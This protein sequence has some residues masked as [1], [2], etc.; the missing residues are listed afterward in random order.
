MRVFAAFILL[1]VTIFSDVR[2]VKAAPNGE[3][4]VYKIWAV[5]TQNE[6]G[7][8][9]PIWDTM[10]IADSQP[11]GKELLAKF[12]NEGT[13][14]PVDED[15]GIML[16]LNNSSID[17]TAAGVTVIPDKGQ[18]RMA[19]N[20]SI[21]YGGLVAS[22]LDGNIDDD[23]VFPAFT[24]DPTNV[25]DIS[26]C[27][28][29]YPYDCVTDE[30]DNIILWPKHRKYDV[31]STH[32]V[33]DE[34]LFAGTLTVN[35]DVTLE[36]KDYD[37]EG[38]GTNGGFIEASW[39]DLQ[40]KI[41]MDKPSNEWAPAFIRVYT[42]GWLNIG[43][44]GSLEVGDGTELIFDDN[45]TCNEALYSQMIR[46]D[47]SAYVWNNT[48]GKLRFVYFEE[49]DKWVY[50]DPKFTVDY[51][52]CWRRDEEQEKDVQTGIV[53]VNGS[54]VSREDRILFNEGEELTFS[55][56][57]PEDRAGCSINVCVESEEYFY[58]TWADGDEKLTITDNSFSFTPPNSDQFWVR[59]WWSDYDRFWIDNDD[60]FVVETRG[61]EGSITAD[62][63]GVTVLRSMN[64]PNG[65][66]GKKQIIKKSDL[67]GTLGNKIKFTFT[68]SDERR[69]E[70]A[71]FYLDDGQ[72]KKYS[73]RIDN[74]DPNRKQINAENGFTDTDGVYTYTFNFANYNRTDRIYVDANFEGS[75]LKENKYFV[76]FDECNEWDDDQGKDIPKAFVK[77]GGEELQN[78]NYDENQPLYDYTIG[79]PVEFTLV[80]P[81]KRDGCTPI[82]EID[83]GLG[84][85][86]SSRNDSGVD[87]DHRI[88]IQNNKFSFT[89]KDKYGF[90][91]RIWWSDYDWFGPG[92]GQFIVE[93]NGEGGTVTADLSGVTVLRSMNEPNGGSGKKQIVE[94]SAISNTLNNKIKFTFTPEANR[95][96]WNIDFWMDGGDERYCLAKDNDP[97]RKQ[98]NA[99]SGFSEENGVYTYTIDVSKYDTNR[100]STYVWFDDPQNSWIRENKYFV[101][102]DEWWRWDHE[103]QED[104]QQGFVKVGGENLLRHDDN[105]DATFYD[106]T[107][108]TPITFTL[109]APEEREGDTPTVEIETGLGEF[110]SSRADSGV[111]AD[112][113][114]SISNGNSVT[115]TPS[116]RYGFRFFVQWSDF[117]YFGYND[118]EEFLIQTEYWDKEQGS[119]TLNKAAD[120]W[121]QESNGRTGVKSRFSNNVLDEAEPLRVVITPSEG[122]HVGSIDFN[123]DKRGEEHV[124]YRYVTGTPDPNNQEERYMFEDGSGFTIEGDVVYYTVPKEAKEAYIGLNVDFRENHD[125]INVYPHGRKVWYRIDNATDYTEM[126]PDDDDYY[127]LKQEV[128]ENADQIQFKFTETN[129]EE[130]GVWVDLWDDNGD[131]CWLHALEAD[132][133]YTLRKADMGGVWKGIE[134]E[135]ID[136]NI[137]LDG[138][139]MFEWFG[140]TDEMNANDNLLR[141]TAYNFTPGNPITFSFKDSV[142]K[143]VVD[144]NW[145]EREVVTADNAG[146]YSYTPSDYKALSFKVFPTEDEYHYYEEVHPYPNQFSAEYDVNI[147]LDENNNTI[148]GLGGTVTYDVDT[149]EVGGL[150]ETVEQ[151]HFIRNKNKL[152]LQGG[153]NG[154]TSITLTI[155]P[156]IGCDYDVFV[157]GEDIT[158]QVKANQ[159]K[160]VWDVSQPWN[161]DWILVD[162]HQGDTPLSGTVTV[163][164]TAKYNEILTATLTGEVNEEALQYQWYRGEEAIDGAT[165][166]TYETVKEDISKVISCKV[167][168]TL[169]SGTLTGTMNNAIAKADGFMPP[170][171]LA[172]VPATKAGN[173]DGKIT[174]VSV[175]MEYATKSDFSDKKDCNGTEITGLKAGT[176]YV[177]MKETDVRKESASTSVTV[178][179]GPADLTGTVSI[180][181][182]TQYG[183][184][185]TAKVTGSNAT[186]FNYQWKRD[187]SNISNATSST[188]KLVKED[189]G[190]TIS[191]VISDKSGNTIGT[192]TGN[193]SV[194]IAKADGPAAPANLKAAACTKKG[195][196]DGQI[197]GVNASMEYATKSDFSDRKSCSST[198]TGLKAGTYYVRIA[199]TDT[200]KAGASVTVTVDDGKEEAPQTQDELVRAFV[201]RF[202]KEVL[203]R[204][205]D[206]IDAD[207]E[208]I[209]DWTTVLL[210]KEKSGAEV[211]YG[212]VN[213]SEFKNR[214]L[215]NDQF[216]KTMYKSFF[217]R[218]PFDPNNYDEGGY[219][220]WYK[221]LQNG[222]KTRLQVFEGFVN[223]GEFRNLCAEYGIDPGK[224]TAPAKQKDPELKPLNVD[225]SGV[226]DEQLTAFVERLYIKALH[227]DEIDSEG[228][229]YWKE[230]IMNGQDA[231]GREY[232][233]RTVI[234][235]GFF[236][237]QE[238]KNKDTTNQEF[239][240]DCYQAFFNRNPIGT[241]D[242]VNYWKWVKELN[243]GMSRQRMIENGFGN[244]QEFKNL[245]E[246][247]GFKIIKQ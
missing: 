163:S 202:Y 43:T 135:M 174:G 139:Y 122:N 3:A 155:T 125:T 68:P 162:F 5:I 226:N 72:E 223:S 21:S 105:N 187:N 12:V 111:D 217:N 180:S 27:F 182:K 36:V 39:I 176:Y 30:D 147:H 214:D 218:D 17:L 56:V 59:V 74:E 133:T 211:A 241:D 29:P 54:P 101:E 13:Y 104:V 138:Q 66:S 98:I 23:N 62:L 178:P 91:V 159:N 15:Y 38:G 124:Y 131:D 166:T 185:L 196:A 219:N 171:G 86:Y 106:Y 238:Y 79:T 243:N 213:S 231:G 52:E 206:Q 11:D 42:N 227:R 53:S 216:V 100:V 204:S 130:R 2:I 200:T 99:E 55:L 222:S 25:K 210:T 215:N 247:Y 18:W 121:I 60:E 198:V 88:T 80:A 119:V 225:K 230:V 151:H 7:E 97:E 109:V 179:D 32:T 129:G 77:V 233:I 6:Y 94:R 201:V 234:S 58:A 141:D 87:A 170:D 123:Y 229:N 67:A 161:I 24:G 20:S 126:I 148:P 191:C 93:T 157:R 113:L 208:G 146:V 64:E 164:G 16:F 78:I 14:N 224:Y 237:S 153:D 160:Y 69:L 49:N 236:L 96:L 46:E 4:D 193:T 48:H 175:L 246:E 239:V 190:K 134:I 143:V 89:P 22:S 118:E 50:L 128:F 84:E 192:I 228:A 245:I 165:E 137:P 81:E 107:I 51:D 127:I 205:Q 199:E 102:Y 57:Q 183:Q 188:Y 114:I 44:K 184:T 221:A 203:G 154:I 63:S 136:R 83:T 220:N 70:R 41:K 158:A 26:D 169:Q 92:D 209:N 31:V 240:L 8:D 189:I 47:G 235:K 167:T 177:R 34:C 40:G 145:K 197:T 45:A 152:I 108:G 75:W 76:E 35:P 85:W 149:I 110:Y 194:Q 150:S 1:F 186:T 115:F 37:A 71:D 73:I 156:N 103:Q 212:F 19:G 117:D 120:A 172:G 28:G 9:E 207:A 181:G 195:S 144:P 173:A 82:V 90:I 232:D 168:S 61:N 10:E 95:R 65:G 132:S 116:D 33:Y 244:S 140:T 112:H 142:Y 242:E